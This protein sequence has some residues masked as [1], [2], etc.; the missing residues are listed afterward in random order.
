MNVSL[1]KYE[2]TVRAR[3]RSGE[4]AN[5]SEYL[6]H[7]IRIAE[8]VEAR[9]APPGASFATRQE[10]QRLLDEGMRNPGAPVTPRRK[11]AIYERAGE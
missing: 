7:C 11:R 8:L 10:L 6:R 9:S 3:I 2:P 1:L 5:A 4:F